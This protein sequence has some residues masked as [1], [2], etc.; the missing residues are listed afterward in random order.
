VTAVPEGLL[1][2]GRGAEPATLP[3]VQLY[4]RLLATAVAHA[5][6]GPP[7]PRV[8]MR[9][10]EGDLEPFRLERWLAPTSAADDRI[11]ARA[12]APVLDVGCGPGRLLEALAAQ[13]KPALGVDLVPAAVGIAR[14]RGGRAVQ[15]SIFRDVPGA[16]AWATAL[17]LDGNIGIGGLPAAL[18]ERVAALLRPGGEAIVETDPPGSPTRTTRVRI[19]SDGAVSDWFAWARVAADA[20]A[21]VARQA[22]MEAVETFEDDARWFVR[23]VSP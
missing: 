2:A 11:V 7:V 16:G 23:L 14:A 22:G 19:E 8:R 20:I 3:A 6:G 21:P 1:P 10:A 15:G 18:L 5:A 13:G 17:L 9:S 12:V 4:A